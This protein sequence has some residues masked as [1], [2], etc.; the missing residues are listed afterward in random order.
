[1]DSL[2]K[3]YPSRNN[4]RIINA[5]G[6]IIFE[7]SDRKANKIWAEMLQ[8]HKPKWWQPLSKEKKDKTNRYSRQMDI[9]E[10]N[11]I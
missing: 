10:V 6:E 2:E 4:S 7:G 8:S 3:S 11:L 9:E 5:N 1:M